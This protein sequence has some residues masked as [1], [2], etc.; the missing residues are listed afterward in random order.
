MAERRASLQMAAARSSRHRLTGREQT[1]SYKDRILAL[2]QQHNPAKVCEVDN[3]MN[4]YK[5]R[6]Q[7]LYLK[8]CNK[9]KVKPQSEIAA[10]GA[11]PPLAS[12]HRPQ[13]ENAPPS[14]APCHPG[15]YPQRQ[16]QLQIR[17]RASYPNMNSPMN[18]L[19]VA[20]SQRFDDD[21]PLGESFSAAAA[22]DRQPE[23][24]PT[25][26]EGGTLCLSTRVEYSA[27][28]R[29]S[30][31]EV[32]GLVTIQAP[33]ANSEQERQAMD[34]ICVLDVSGSMRGDKLRQVQDAV[35]F[36]IDQA[37]PTDRL[38]L[39]TFNSFAKRALRLRR[40]DTEGRDE[41]IAET[42]RLSAGG[43]TSIASGLET[44]VQVM[45]QRRQRNRVSAIL[46]LTDGIDG[47]ARHRLPSL[48]G[49]ARAAGCALYTFGFGADHDAGLLSEVAEQAE[50]PFTYVEDTE[51]IREAFAGAVGGLASIVAQRVELTLAGH[52]ALKAVHTAFAVQ[53]ASESSAV[54][55]IPDIF[56]GERRD[57]VVELVVPAAGGAAG[58]TVLLEASARY[59]DLTRQR[60]AGVLVQ[61]SAVL[62]QAERVEEAQ[63]EAEPDEEVSAQRERVEVTQALQEAA[64][65]SDEGRFEAAQQ[66]L[67]AADQRLESA[68]RKEKTRVHNALAQELADARGRMKS[69]GAWEQGGRAE[70][71]D[72]CQMHKMQ[73]C[74]N[75]SSSSKGGVQKSSKMMY[76]SAQQDEWVQKSKKC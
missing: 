13:P 51:H 19:P 64:A 4:K 70:V 71:R 20:E 45:E 75:T 63:P 12:C 48:V 53:R 38:G 61:S 76:I 17:S 16:R 10:A 39:V 23:P 31:Q 46:L 36:V 68:G 57:V 74:T 55:S 3:L 67:E 7:E 42:L 21:D 14:V 18:T 37:L 33:T 41:A 72:A 34:L 47:S 25:P 54:V 35:R 65:H 27:L 26:I 52:V 5:G 56:A 43:G 44:A 49:R 62:M 50:T 73:R 1:P 11:P 40:M 32:F 30:S 66:V 60:G 24:D 69:R 8:V 29:G 22:Q 6:E 9:Y 28:P 58:T 59:A 15:G 2:L